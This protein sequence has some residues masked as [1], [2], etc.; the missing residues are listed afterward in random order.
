MPTPT[1]TL[2]APPRPSDPGISAPRSLATAASGRQ[3]FVQPPAGTNALIL[4]V[5]VHDD[6]YVQR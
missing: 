2:P 5:H 1:G 4:E 3:V 6:L